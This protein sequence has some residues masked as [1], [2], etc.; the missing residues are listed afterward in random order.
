MSDNL[1]ASGYNLAWLDTQLKNHRL[2]SPRQVFLMTVDDSGS[3]VCIPK[4]APQ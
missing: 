3:V 2:T 1:T 4:E